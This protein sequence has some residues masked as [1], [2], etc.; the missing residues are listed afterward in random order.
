MDA[1]RFECLKCGAE[2]DQRQGRQL[3][4]TAFVLWIG[5]GAKQ[6]SQAFA[7]RTGGDRHNAYPQLET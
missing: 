1:N 6:T 7:S 3:D 5:G 4:R 2:E